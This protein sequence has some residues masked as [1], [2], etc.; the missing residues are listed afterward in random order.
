[1]ESPISPK[2]RRSLRLFGNLRGFT[3]I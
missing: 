1:V 2:R 3:P